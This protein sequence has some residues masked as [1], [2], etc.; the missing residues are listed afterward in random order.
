MAELPLCPNSPAKEI[1]A[2]QQ[3]RPTFLGQIF[4]FLLLV[5]F[6]S[7]PPELNKTIAHEPRH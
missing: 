6:Y 3:L 2:E 7:F 5:Q 1:W 4:T